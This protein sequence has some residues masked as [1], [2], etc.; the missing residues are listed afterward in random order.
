MQ[1]DKEGTQEGSNDGGQDGRINVPGKEGG[2]PCGGQDEVRKEE[3][4]TGNG[5]MGTGN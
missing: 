2:L 1:Q 5:A 3:Q 4:M